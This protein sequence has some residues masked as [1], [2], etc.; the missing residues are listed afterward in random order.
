MEFPSPQF[1]RD[2]E[3]QKIIYFY[4]ACI[5]DMQLCITDLK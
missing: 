1:T 2:E 3:E 4:N 5:H